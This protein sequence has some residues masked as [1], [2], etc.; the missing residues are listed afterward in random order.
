MELTNSDTDTNVLYSDED[1]EK[2]NG[3]EIEVQC[4]EI[5]RIESHDVVYTDKIVQVLFSG[6]DLVDP[7]IFNS[8]ELE[9]TTLGSMASYR[10]K[11]MVRERFL[12]NANILWL[13]RDSH[14]TIY[15]YS[16]NGIL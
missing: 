12:R 11:I 3:N 16:R 10:N 7:N 2:F 15:Q 8:S 5:I 13:F 6:D 9:S 1:K 4:D 14:F